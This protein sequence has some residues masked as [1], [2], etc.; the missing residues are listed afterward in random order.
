MRLPLQCLQGIQCWN[1]LRSLASQCT[2]AA[3]P[4]P[5]RSRAALCCCPYEVEAVGCKPELDPP[6]LKVEYTH[7]VTRPYSLKLPSSAPARASQC[8]AQLHP[9]PRIRRSKRF[10]E[11]LCFDCLNPA[12]LTRK[13]QIVPLETFQLSLLF[14]LFGVEMRRIGRKRVTHRMRRRPPGSVSTGQLSSNRRPDME[15]ISSTSSPDGQA[16]SQAWE[17][18]A[19]ASFWASVSASRAGEF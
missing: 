7:V 18:A 8:T 19:A 12:H 17:A 5:L 15:M 16:L 1:L 10:E 11:G 6:G 14:G 3:F 9:Q 13:D 2:E 4:E